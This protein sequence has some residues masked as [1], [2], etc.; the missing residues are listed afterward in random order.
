MVFEKEPFQYRGVQAKERGLNWEGVNRAE[1]PIL[2][3]FLD[4]ATHRDP[5]Q[6]FDSVADALAALKASQLVESQTGT[7]T[8]DAAQGIIGPRCRRRRPAE[9]HEEQVEWLLSLLQSYPGWR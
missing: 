1:C 2:A 9:L 3:A 5:E 4:K 7:A 6:R 8:K